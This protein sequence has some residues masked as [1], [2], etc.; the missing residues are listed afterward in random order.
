MKNFRRILLVS[1]VGVFASINLYAQSG[2]LLKSSELR[3]APMLDA[4][5]IKVIPKGTKIFI[6]EKHGEWARV[7]NGYIFSVTVGDKLPTKKTP[8][9]EAKK[10]QTKKVEAKIIEKELTLVHQITKIV[11]SSDYLLDKKYVEFDKC[12]KFGWCK[13]K[14]EDSYVKRY[15]YIKQ[16]D[17]R[18]MKRGLDKAYIYKKVNVSKVDTEVLKLSAFD[19]KGEKR[20]AI[21]SK[22]N[23]NFGYVKLKNLINDNSVSQNQSAQKKKIV[24]ENNPLPKE[25]NLEDDNTVAVEEP[26]IEK[27]KEEKKELSAAEKRLLELQKMIEEYDRQLADLNKSK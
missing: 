13:I 27:K 17:G 19:F 26:K 9:I 2:V 6:K 8:K 5:V 15:L 3:K 4:P 1:L 11:E 25:V 22:K 12:D 10:T 23:S 21:N 24:V 14:G 18:Y 7:Q 16:D 20:K